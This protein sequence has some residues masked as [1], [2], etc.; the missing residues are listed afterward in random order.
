M[1][2]VAREIYNP[3]NTTTTHL[4][5]LLEFFKGL[6]EACDIKDLSHIKN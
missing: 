3:Q 1:I 4:R 5:D 6:P 2:S